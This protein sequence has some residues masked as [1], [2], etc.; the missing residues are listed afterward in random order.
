M[1]LDVGCGLRPKTGEGWETLDKR[2][3]IPMFN[4]SIYKPDIVANILE[5][6][7]RPDGFY[8]FVRLSSVLEHFDK[9]E[10][11]KVLRECYRV[12]DRVGWIWIS[13]PNMRSASRSLAAGVNEEMIMNLIYGENDYPENAHKW[14]YTEG[15]LISL[16]S[17]IG[18]KDQQL[19][20]PEQYEHELV[21]KAMK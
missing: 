3:E 15:M 9:R 20:M 6:I 18:F 1:K 19:V 10:N 8:S 2:A 11:I 12:L 13:V 4:H 16:L 17:S 7:P 14:G 5:G 21:V